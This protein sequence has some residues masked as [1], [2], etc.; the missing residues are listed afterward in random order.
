[1]NKEEIAILQAQMVVAWLAGLIILK[2]LPVA[3]Q[4]PEGLV[5]PSIMFAE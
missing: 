4:R 2:H 5:N 3:A 1:M